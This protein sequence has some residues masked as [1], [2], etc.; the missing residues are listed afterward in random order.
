MHRV[1]ERVDNG[2]VYKVH[3]EK[4]PRTLRVL[5]RNL[6]LPV[7]D[8][9]L[10]ENIPAQRQKNRTSSR[11][12]RSKTQEQQDENS[13]SEGEENYAYTR[14]PCYRLVMREP[15][16]HLQPGQSHP[17]DKRLNITAQGFAPPVQQEQTVTPEAQLSEN[18]GH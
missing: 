9:P 15:T 12:T 4:G 17:S 16:N 13:D 14:V 2:P 11:Q 10:E 3:S 5:H 6:L 8:L 7:N 18:T 1:V